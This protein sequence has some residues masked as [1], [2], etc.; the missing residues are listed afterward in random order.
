MYF[1]RAVGALIVGGVTV[2]ALWKTS[3]PRCLWALVLIPV[4]FA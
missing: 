1:A 3:E 2:Y 4:I